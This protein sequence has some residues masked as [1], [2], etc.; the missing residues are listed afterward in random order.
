MEKT[1][2]RRALHIAGAVIAVLLAIGLYKAK[3]D[4][5]RTEAHVR[6]LRSEIAETERDLRVLRA[7]IARRESPENIERLA[8]E[9][10]GLVV[11]G[12]SAALPE[13]ALDQRLPPARPAPNP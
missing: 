13:G 12:Q 8:E 4:A 7:E 6:A 2:L 1:Q 10:L 9:R 11:G 3:T 5:A